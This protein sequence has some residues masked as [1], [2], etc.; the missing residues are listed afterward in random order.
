[1]GGE[2]ASASKLVAHWPNQYSM[3]AILSK[4][5]FLSLSRTG[6]LGFG[7]PPEDNISSVVW[8]TIFVGLGLPAVI[9]VL[10]GI[11]LIIRK[12]PWKKVMKLV[13]S[14]RDGYQ[15]LDEHND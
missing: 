9:T 2:G 4:L 5:R 8:I 14:N 15:A 13:R 3:G 7:E 12:K 6:I 11:Y 10:G 1:M